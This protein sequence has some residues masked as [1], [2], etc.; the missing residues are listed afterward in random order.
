MNVGFRCHR[1]GTFGLPL[2]WSTGVMF[3]LSNGDAG[4]SLNL[5]ASNW[6]LR[7]FKSCVLENK[8][9]KNFVFKN[10]CN[11]TSIL[12][13]PPPPPAPVRKNPKWP[14]LP[15]PSADV[16]NGWPLSVCTCRNIFWK[17]YL[18]RQ[19]EVL[20]VLVLL[21]VPGQTPNI[22]GHRGKIRVPGQRRHGPSHIEQSLTHIMLTMLTLGALPDPAGPLKVAGPLGFCPPCPPSR[23][24]CHH[25]HLTPR[26]TL[27]WIPTSII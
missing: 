11:W 26:M 4:H 5:K 6:I 12:G 13:Q 3:F 22:Q 8:T 15:P 25:L 18:K 2:E 10:K 9:N 14:D 1:I 21:G 16:L 24:A 23:R 27:T 19:L 20:P 17:F 7:I